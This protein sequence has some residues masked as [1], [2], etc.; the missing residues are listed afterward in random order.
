MKIHHVKS[1]I[2]GHKITSA[3]ALVVLSTII[4]SGYKYVFPVLETNQYYLGTVR[5]GDLITSLSGSGQISAL[6]Q[7]DLKPKVSGD[8][9][10]V[11]AV[12]GQWIS[13]G[14]LIAKLDTTS[15]E[16]SVRDAEI[17]L[18]T[19]RL[20]LQKLQEPAD[21]LS[22]IQAENNLFQAETN[23]EKNYDDG[24]SAVSNTFLDLPEAMT[25]LQ[26]VLYGAIGG[27][28]YISYYTD[29]VKKND[30]EVSIYRDSAE[31][32]YNLARTAYDQNFKDY[33]G[34][35]RFS[36]ISTK[37]SLI[38]NTHAA[39]ESLSDAI[40]SASDL[41]SFVKDRL[42]TRNMPTPSILNTNQNL[43][44]SYTS[45]INADFSTLSNIKNNIDAYKRAV[46][47]QT[48]SLKKLRAGA[49]FLDIES[50]RLSVTQKENQL[51]DAKKNLEDY[52][53]KA[54]FSGTVAKV[55]VKQF[56]VAGPSTIIATMITGQR[57]AEI[58]LN[59]IDAA[60][61]SLGDKTILTFDAI[62]GLSLEGKVGEIDTLGTANQGVVNYNVKINFDTEDR[63]IKPGM[64][65]NASIVTDTKSDV[66]LVPTNA[67]KKQGGKKYV[68]LFYPPVE[69][70][71]A[72]QI[73]SSQTP[74]NR[75]VETGISNDTETEVISGLEE[76]EKIIIRIISGDKEAPTQSAPSLFNAIPGG[77]RANSSGVRIQGG[78][79]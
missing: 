27:Q 66:L 9:I 18:E 37:E 17:S 41:I 3:A 64:S 58:S 77:G 72:R 31:K 6:K 62:D 11:G 39:T 48:E 22:L 4:Y 42:T 33:K 15:A 19:S 60:K 44:S 40:K 69:E 35:S 46:N 7:T 8:V 74:I 20:S 52:Y 30:P 10:Y 43:L 73:T 50:L 16:K 36:D 65:V 55:N 28:D 53:I 70:S 57:V 54:P 14:S 63:R 2:K 61:V 32:K 56:D 24:F 12:G 71:R 26:N 5:K 78:I 21:T 34:A 59:E 13:S 68:Q 29:L 47:I 49:D 38:T 79:R 51:L 23:L 1:F 67:I 75:P 45:K 25:G 76:G